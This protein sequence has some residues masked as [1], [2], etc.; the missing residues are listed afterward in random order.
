[1]SWSRTSHAGALESETAAAATNTARS[2][3]ADAWSLRAVLHQHWPEYLMEAAELGVFM[4]A[5]SLSVALLFHPSSPLVRIMPDRPMRRVLTG[6]LMG[7]TASAIVYS[8][9]GRRSGA[10]FNPAVTLAFWRLG[11]V[12]PADAVFYIAA[13]FVGA[14]LGVL[15]SVAVLGGLIA[16]PQVNYV[17]T[18][19]GPGGPAA[20]FAAE[21]LISFTLMA[22]V[23]IVS[24][25]PSLAA[26]TGVFCGALVATYISLEAPISGMSM[27]PARTFAPALVG[28]IWTGLWIYFT[29]PPLGMLA[30]AG[31]IARMRGR[32]L[33]A[34]AKLHHQ[35]SYRCI[36]CDYRRRASG[37]RASSQR[38]GSITRQIPTQQ[39]S[40]QQPALGGADV[41]QSAL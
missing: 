37:A 14:V 11:K 21:A 22:V 13:Q 29:A 18:L 2:S 1:M 25:T 23:L 3:G 36:F 39:P 8:P 30:A 12:A 20:A 7:L 33:A 15:S 40:N 6:I 5:A 26:Y 24:N 4:I 31:A 19:P 9:W 34:C 38:A 10:H 16:H 27:N 28:N 41:R 32:Q 17:A 35:D